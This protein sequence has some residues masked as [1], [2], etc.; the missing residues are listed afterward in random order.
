[1]LSRGVRNRVAK[2]APH[3][4]VAVRIEL[5][6]CR[7]PEEYEAAFSL[8][9]SQVPDGAVVYCFLRDLSELEYRALVEGRQ[10]TPS[11]V[12]GVYIKP[13]RLTTEGVGGEGRQNQRCEPVDSEGPVQSVL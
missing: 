1:M 5:P 3:E 12:L 4:A 11:A 2:L 13:L 7:T 8:A 6:L 9:W 10:A